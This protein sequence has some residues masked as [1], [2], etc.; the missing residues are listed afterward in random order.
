MSRRAERRDPDFEASA[1]M[2]LVDLQRSALG[3]AAPARGAWETDIQTEGVAPPEPEQELR[4]AV[5]RIEASANPASEVI[6][7]AVVTLALSVANEGA[8]TAGAVT[9]CAPLPAGAAYRNGSFALDGRPQR[10]EMAEDLFAGELRVPDL[11]PGSRVTLLWKVGV[12]LGNKP[13]VISPSARAGSSAV[14]GGEAVVVSRKEGAQ[15]ATFAGEVT[16]YD[17]ALY[18]PEPAPRELP[19]YELDEEEQL[20]HEAA[21]AALAEYRPP[22]EPPAEPS[23]PP[24]QPEPL[25]PPAQPAPVQEPGTPVEEPFHPPPPEQPPDL[26]PAAASRHGIV[27][28]GR[29]DRPSLAYFERL[30]GAGKPPTLL[31]HFIL[32]G[33]LACTRDATGADA[34]GLNEHMEAQGQLLQR[35]VLHE[36]LG[37]KEPI[38]EY[39]GRVLARLDELGPGAITAPAAPEPGTILLIREIDDP[40]LASLRKLQEES[41]R[42]DFTRAR[43]LTLALTARSLHASAPREPLDEAQRR[44]DAYVRTAQTQLQRFFVRMRLDRTT[45]LLYMQDELLDAAA[46]ALLPALLTLF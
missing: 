16:R 2:R 17:R 15:Q 13:L 3:I 46:R 26:E 37:K 36:K 45:G 25:P 11:A 12:K 4:S 33:A 14:I 38:A 23:V 40:T 8:A 31:T 7:G 9:L 35:I 39:A 41:A 34:V 43:Q 22:F 5:L 1:D 6:P 27:L 42:W 44:L 18:A 28:Y 19:I 20:E 32:V 21:D 29:I 30:F 24:A 10:D